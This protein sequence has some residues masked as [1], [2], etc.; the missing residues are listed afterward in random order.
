MDNW[1]E[2]KIPT[3]RF[4]IYCDICNWSI[5]NKPNLLEVQRPGKQH[6]KETGHSLTCC[7][8][9]EPHST[10]KKIHSLSEIGR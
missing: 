7:K 9:N 4:D 6:A 5:L 2:E 3:M 1:W 10:L 8:D